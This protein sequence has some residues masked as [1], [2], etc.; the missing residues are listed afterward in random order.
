MV[1]TLH[2]KW[3]VKGAIKQT[4]NVPT[5]IARIFLCCSYSFGSPSH[6]T[7]KHQG[8]I[9]VLQNLQLQQ[10][11]QASEIR[12]C[13]GVKHRRRVSF[14]G[15]IHQKVCFFGFLLNIQSIWGPRKR[16]GKMMCSF[17]LIALGCTVWL[18]FL[19]AT[20][21]NI[22]IYNMIYIHCMQRWI[23]IRPAI[24]SET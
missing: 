15:P 12:W 22:Y 14:T 11:K 3:M 17:G 9:G 21:S 24:N 16:R 4:I 18:V 5:P 7:S 20:Y 2:T 23:T 19:D 6:H 10:D 13:S 8:T 1:W